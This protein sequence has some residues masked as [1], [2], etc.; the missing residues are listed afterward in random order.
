MIAVTCRNGEHFTLDPDSIER[1]EF[2]GDVSVFLEDR[3]RHVVRGGFDELL[4]RVRDDRAT[5]ISARRRL[6]GPV[7]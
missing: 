3:R 4:R 7:S 1:V 6:V 5:R 2:D